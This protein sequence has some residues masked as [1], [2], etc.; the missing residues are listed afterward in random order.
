MMNGKKTAA[1][2]PAAKKYAMG[3][4]VA[5]PF[6][7][8]NAAAQFQQQQSMKSSSSPQTASMMGRAPTAAERTVLSEQSKV[9]ST[10]APAPSVPIS[11]RKGR[12]MERMAKGGAVTK[13]KP[14]AAV[15]IMIAM[16]AKGKG[17]TKMAMGGCATKK[18]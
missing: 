3:G 7:L 15:A 1:K 9:G 12:T 4:G 8:A 10:A 14:G 11:A 18:K 13:K 2:K 16:P 5:S 6:K 17:K